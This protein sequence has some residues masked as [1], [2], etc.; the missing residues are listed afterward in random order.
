MSDI[1]HK[2]G[3]KDQHVK[4]QTKI[5]ICMFFFMLYISQSNNQFQFTLRYSGTNK[6]IV[7]NNNL[8]RAPAKFNWSVICVHWIETSPSNIEF[9][10]TWKFAG[11]WQLRIAMSNHS[12][13][14]HSIQRNNRLCVMN[15]CMYQR[16][17]YIRE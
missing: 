12:A 14:G 5:F 13:A 17:V 16:A 6:S 7:A 15:V 4:Y 9:V 8:K 2:S 10:G 3:S 1:R 11:Q